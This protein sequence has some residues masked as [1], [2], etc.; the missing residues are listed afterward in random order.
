SPLHDQVS[1]VD[2]VFQTEKL[3]NVANLCFIDR[4]PSTL[5]HF[6]RF[7]LGWEN[8]R[9]NRQEIQ[10]V[11]TCSQLIFGNRELRHAIEYIKH[12]RVVH[13]RQKLQRSVPKQEFRRFNCCFIV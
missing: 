6:P 7:S 5:D 4:Y 12:R 3:I 9:S 10:Y 8:R 13:A 11:Y 2:E 1:V